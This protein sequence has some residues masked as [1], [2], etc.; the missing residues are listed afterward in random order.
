MIGFLHPKSNHGCLVEFATPPAGQHHAAPSGGLFTKLDHIGI[1]VKDLA[2]GVATFERHFGLTADP[3]RGGHVAALGINNAFIPVGP[4]GE[5][6]LEIIESVAPE[7]PVATF[8]KDRG[9]GFFLLSV[10][11]TS[12]A[13]AVAKLR[14]AGARASDPG[15]TGTA[16]VSMRSTHGVN[17]QLVQRS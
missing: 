17:L 7:G 4:D 10:A 16:F 11:V 9:E 13:E 15:P 2:T 8:A 5:A 14:E 12:G 1:V 3:K 6:D